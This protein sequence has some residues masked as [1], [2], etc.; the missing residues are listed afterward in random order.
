MNNDKGIFILTVLKKIL[1]ILI[2]Q[3]KFEGIDYRITDS[4]VGA[5]RNR[6]IKNHLFIIYGIITL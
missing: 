6:S 3:D 4:N 2:Y 1:D 5:R